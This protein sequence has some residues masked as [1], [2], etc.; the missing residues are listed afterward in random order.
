MTPNDSRFKM[1]K[2]I[3]LQCDYATCLPHNMDSTAK[4]KDTRAHKEPYP[5]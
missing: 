2:V 3:K 5:C 4:Q 1:H